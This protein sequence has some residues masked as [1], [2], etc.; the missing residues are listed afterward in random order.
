MNLISSLA[1]NIRSLTLE[2]PAQPLQPYSVLMDMLGMTITDSGMMVNEKTAMRQT[3]VFA[4]VRVISQGSAAFPRPV[5]Q[6][7]TNGKSI[8]RDHR[9]YPILNDQPNEQMT[10]MVMFEGLEA[11]RQLWGNAYA[12]IQRDKANRA[13]AIWPLPSDRT[14]AVRKNGQLV[15]VT[16]ATTQGNPRYIDPR[17][18]IHVPGMAFDG[19]MGISPIQLAKQTIGKALA[20]ERFGAQYFGNGA[21]P[22]GAF[23]YS[24]GNLSAEAKN[25]LQKT[26]Q[27]ASS[28]A[29]ALRPLL[30]ENGMDWKPMSVPNNEAQ[31]IEAMKFSIPEICRIFG[32]QPHL[33]HDLERSTNNNIEQQ[34]LEHV[35][36]CLRPVAIRWEQELNRK[37]FAG[38]GYFVEHSMQGLLR[39]DFKTRMEGYQSLF[40]VGG[41]TPNMIAEN[42][43]WNPIPAGMGGDT[44]FV[45]MNMIPL[46]GAQRTL[47][48]PQPQTD[49]GDGTTEDPSDPGGANNGTPQDPNSALRRERVLDS[50]RHLFR[51]AVERTISRAKR[52]QE[53]VARIWRP[54]MEVAAEMLNLCAGSADGLSDDAR[55]FAHRCAAGV[56]VRAEG[57]KLDNSD[58][59]T[60]GEL[61]SAYESISSHII[62]GGQ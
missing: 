49:G 30:L 33:V 22:S 44:R 20:Q 14:N 28:G 60:E 50:C 56:W 15:Y 24:G 18:V 40:Q 47:D 36:Y 3:T 52:D 5:Y 12:E 51:N 2:D 42:E 59:V 48:N 43:G 37:L 58:H 6:L 13:V 27:S 8:A 29:N 23:V 38:S 45:P 39:G 34:S 11:Q 54:V 53:T 7:K 55:G 16:T 17:D 26:L 19:L 32:V 4:C 10:A 35:M 31:F 62:G 41:I 21:R 25:N 1:A 9:L 57:W 61:A 46:E